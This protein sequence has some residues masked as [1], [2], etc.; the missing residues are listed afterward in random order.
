M[1]LEYG[2]VPNVRKTTNAN[3]IYLLGSGS[4]LCR[5]AYS[6]PVV[7]IQIMHGSHIWGCGIEDAEKPP[8]PSSTDLNVIGTGVGNCF[9]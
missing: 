7:G 3:G 1:P 6:R 5:K 9:Q 2:D 8:D 4:R